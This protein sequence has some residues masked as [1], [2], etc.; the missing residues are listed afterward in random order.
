[1]FSAASHRLSAFSHP[2]RRRSALRSMLAL[3]LWTVSG[4][5]LIST[6]RADE[7]EKA[8]DPKPAV[9]STEQ[10]VLPKLDEM[11][12]PDAEAL[13][14]ARPFDWIVLKTQDVL[15]VDAI[16]IRPDIFGRLTIK[17][18]M[19]T[20][21]YNRLLKH[22]P[23]K[24][25]EL[26]SLRQFD[27]DE[28]RIQEFADREA[29]LKQELDA[30]RDRPD[31]FKPATYKLLIA[32]QDGSV[33]P[34]YV[35]ELRYV[36]SVV[37]YDDLILRRAGEL[38]DQGRIPLAY[39]L[40][41]L[42]A[43]RHR[44]NNALIL[45]ELDAAEAALH[46]QI[47]DLEQERGALRKSRDELNSPK[48]KGSAAVKMR[49]IVLEKTIVAI[50]VEIRDLEDEIR[51]LRFKMRF[52]RPKDFPNPDAVRKDDLLL[53]S[54]PRFDEIYHRMALA[55]A[56]QQFA[57]GD[58][59]ASLR[60]LEE[61]W[62]PG[63]EIPGLASRLGRLV[64]GLIG[65][66]L[67]RSE[68]RQAR[69]FLA[70]L[71]SRLPTN[72]VV[73]KWRE[74]LAQRAGATLQQAKEAAAQ[75]NFAAA[76]RTVDVAAEIWPPLTGLKETH[77]D[78]TDRYQRLKAGVLHLANEETPA[79]GPTAADERVR[80]L[81]EARLF[82]PASTSSQGVRY[83]SSFFD[84]WEPTDLG[85]RVQFRLKLNRADWEARPLITSADVYAE[86]LSRTNPQSRL[87]D[88]RLAGFVNGISVQG[89]ADFT[90]DFRQLP[91]RPEA[92][93]QIT[94]PIGA[95]TQS[96]NT[97]IAADAAQ[98][99]GRY[100]FQKTDSP[101]GEIR[102]RR[103]RSEPASIRQRHVEEVVEIRY[104]TWER[105][106][107]GLLRGETSF[108][109]AVDPRDLKGLRGDGRF[110]VI[111]YNL[112]RTH[113]LLFN[114]EQRALLDGQFR[115]ALL[116]AVPRQRA[117][118]EILLTEET[119]DAGRLVTCPFPSTSYAYDNQ[120]PQPEYNPALAAALA[121]TARKQFGGEL[122]V[123]TMICPDDPRIRDVSRAL[124]LEWRRV[125]IEVQ[126]VDKLNDGQ[127]WDIC[128]RTAKCIEPLMDTW[129]LLTM[130]TSA[131]V[132]SLQPLSESTRRLLLELERAVDWPSATKLLHRLS[133]DLLIEA[134]YVPL[135]EL[136][137]F[138]VARKN[139]V[140]I[141][142][143]VMHAYDDVERWTVQSW[144][145]QETPP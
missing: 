68:F 136:D 60:L 96:L 8:E 82:E 5:A 138:L 50:A 83:R 134:R 9:E 84:S 131:Q 1:M 17:Q 22:R 126:L 48:N 29:R 109:P 30:A 116:H 97:G 89:P 10:S 42:V 118:Q 24:E 122:P 145:P 124:I 73:Q 81:T 114:P 66:S 21:V 143:R 78:L 16:G 35:L 12:L 25:A 76:A 123:L 13:L 95:E 11:V 125:G 20:Q 107:Q 144:Y 47:K 43:R 132:N 120:L 46:A 27:K 94:V 139:I 28:K 92:L 6:A 106:L 137:E 57:R 100:R 102:Y 71:K 38:I 2:D 90:V 63:V 74:E 141:P 127:T 104:D 45:R 86:L 67:E 133:A 75:G 39:D 72:P 54:W 98:D 56:D 23:Y 112:P 87:Y 113:L 117:L 7:A 26:A 70:N 142:A 55:D 31:T 33:D 52:A 19:A 77:R 64:D 129:P 79:V 4:I 61:L 69:Y 53:P 93:W 80:W 140:G 103:V 115:R 34:E 108:L 62:K 101:Q 49:L 111:P 128:Y 105:A 88:E 18:E 110:Q 51:N 85:R 41:M 65:P 36:E 3:V 40:L 44:D 14:R 135:W 32:L 121:L 119:R 37:Y 58:I 15:V 59:E 130:Q 99:L 91:L